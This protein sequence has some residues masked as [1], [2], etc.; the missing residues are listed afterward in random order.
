MATERAILIYT[1]WPSAT[2]AEAAGRALVEQR[3]AACVNILPAMVSLYRWEG[4]I[5]RGGEAV[6]LIKTR[7]SLAEAAQA[8]VKEMHPYDVPAIAVLKPESWDRAYLDWLIAETA[9]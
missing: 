8:A 7:A 5:E 1:T 9:R 3:L 6:M 2:D 4:R